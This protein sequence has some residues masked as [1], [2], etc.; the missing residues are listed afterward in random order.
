VTH[1][2]HE[3]NDGR[4]ARDRRQIDW[5]ACAA[6]AAEHGRTFYLASRLL[7]PP[8]RRAIL[9]T[10]AYCRTAD[11]IVD[12][13]DAFGPDAALKALDRWEQQLDAPTDPVAR[14]FAVARA[15]YAVPVE[16]VRELLVGIRMDLDVS[17]YASWPDLQRYCHLVAG[18]VGLMVAPILGC[19]NKSALEHAT[20]LG[21]AMQLTNIL[22]DVAEDGRN[23]RL[24]LPL[25]E[26]AAFGCDPESIVAGVGGPG[27]PDLMALQIRRAR[28]LYAR[29]EAGMSALCPSG[30]LT[31]TAASRLYSKILDEIE[32]LNYDVFSRRAHVSTGR[33]VKSLPGVFL[34]F[35]RHSLG[36]SNSA[37]PLPGS[38]VIPDAVQPRVWP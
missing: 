22:R 26:V 29:A 6:I 17:R 38:E 5:G 27:F 23:G 30:R 25:D 13:A 16:P 8:R 36:W 18:T 14:A 15:E 2:A 1:W 20:I 34:S 24:Y 31:A 37:L 11:D 3:A 19:R 33:K 12:K 32:M 28:A 21:I 10:Y 4:A 9:A 7:P 35:G